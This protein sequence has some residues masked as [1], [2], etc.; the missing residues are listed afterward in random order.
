[1][2]F[3]SF[4]LLTIALNL[5][6][7]SAVA[8]V[9]PETLLERG[10]RQ[11]ENAEFELAIMS[12][13]V[14]LQSDI[15]DKDACIKGHKHLAF[16]YSALGYEE[17]AKLEFIRLLEKYPIFDLLLSESPRLMRPYTQAR[18]R[19]EIGKMD[20]QGLVEGMEKKQ[21][22]PDP[23]PLETSTGSVFIIT[24]PWSTVVIDGEQQ[25]PTPL[26]LFKV[27]SGKHRIDFYFTL[28]GK[29]THFTKTI[30]VLENQRLRVVENFEGNEQ[31]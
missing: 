7:G 17:K 14:A 27:S 24:Q 11:Y 16:A 3:K 8:Q 30:F 19:L 2:I 20:M 5:D 1:M 13:E 10:V 23:S 4:I 21:P 29:P 25:G 31:R 26:S 18:T 15:E 9:S 22:E 6:Q 28:D 12:L